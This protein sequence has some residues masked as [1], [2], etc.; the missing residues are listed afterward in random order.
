MGA[1]GV[2]EEIGQFT[3][4]AFMENKKFKA[5]DDEQQKQ[6]DYSVLRETFAQ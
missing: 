1:R 2:N 6:D 5:E 4:L 3:S